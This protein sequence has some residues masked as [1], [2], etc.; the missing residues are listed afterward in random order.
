MGGLWA[1]RSP[2]LPNTRHGHGRRATSG[3]EEAKVQ[4]AEKPDPPMAAWSGETLRERLPGLITPYD[5]SSIDGASYKLKVGNEIYVS[6]TG[7]TEKAATIDQ[8]APRADR[9]IPPGQFA[10]LITSETVKVPNDGI[11]LISIRAR[12]KWRGLV[13]VS[14]FHVDPGYDGKLIFAVFNAGPSTIHIKQ[15]DDCFLIWYLSLDRSSSYIKADGAGYTSIGSDLVSGISGEWKSFDMLDARMR[16]I[17]RKQTAL[18]AV[19][20]ILLT[21]IV[22]IALAFV[23]YFLKSDTDARRAAPMTPASSSVPTA[24][25]PMRTNPAPA[26][27]NNAGSSRPLRSS[28]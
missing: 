27:Q 1:F 7:L 22:G 3:S 23:A 13:N 14:G 5:E 2:R 26:T 16:A 28:P 21:A 19:A 17:E 24:S 20:K 11:A 6:P 10:F 9:T 12:L 15:S 4:C 8:L 18:D 25:A